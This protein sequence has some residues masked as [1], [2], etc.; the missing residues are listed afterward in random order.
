MDTIND[1]L[2]EL[3]KR[4]T[5]PIFVNFIIAWLIFNWRIPLGLFK[6]SL[7]ELPTDGYNS[8]ADLIKKNIET[9]NS[10]LYPLAISLG[11]TFSY[12]VI[13]NLMGAFNTWAHKWGNNWHLK[14]SED[15][16]VP[17]AKYRQMIQNNAETEK[18][19]QQIIT[20]EGKTIQENSRLKIDLEQ[21][22]NNTQ[23][24]DAQVNLWQMYSQKTYLDGDYRMVSNF[25]DNVYNTYSVVIRD[26]TI[27]EKLNNGGSQMMMKIENYAFNFLTFEFLLTIKAPNRQTNFIVN[28]TQRADGMPKRFTSSQESQIIRS[29]VP[30]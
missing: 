25:K 21:A 14:I 22:R 2:K 13:K 28:L 8:Y 30:E 20:T 16:N 27:F 4:F 24:I 6:Y 5:N 12:P 9:D 7:K 26:G 3:R 17:I 23:K 18:Q 15:L 29:L 1:L 10:L 11:Y 19:L